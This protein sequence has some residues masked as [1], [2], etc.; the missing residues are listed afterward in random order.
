MQSNGRSTS[1]T[2][3]MDVR[4]PRI[5][6]VDL[7]DSEP[8]SHGRGH[9]DYQRFSAR[10][11]QEDGHSLFVERDVLRCGKVVGV[12]ALDPGRDQVVLTRQFRL[13][14]Y[15]AA[16]EHETLEIVAG[17]MDPGETSM[18]TARRE[19]REEI[20]VELLQL[21]PLLELMPAPAWADEWMTLF[22][23]RVDAALVP[24]RAGAVDEQENIAV[25]RCSVDESL[26]LVSKRLVHSAPTIIALQWLALNRSSVATLLT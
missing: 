21:V 15:L 19:C 6:A 4:A 13:G 22:L 10:L 5:A 20:G 14:A 18:E 12:L 26:G 1:G 8:V 7:S 16:G 11:T 24:D 9:R 25:V 17:R 3:D 2:E 23:A